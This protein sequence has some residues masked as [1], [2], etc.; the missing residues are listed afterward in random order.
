MFILDT[1]QRL[2]VFLKKPDQGSYRSMD[3]KF[4]IATF[5]SLLLLSV[6]FATIWITCYTW[7]TNFD[8]GKTSHLVSF[9]N[10]WL[11]VLVLV[12]LQLYEWIALNFRSTLQKRK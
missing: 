12:A 2:F 6:V 9:Y 8:W 3:A 1:L 5:F 7:F 10:I 11:V 4:K